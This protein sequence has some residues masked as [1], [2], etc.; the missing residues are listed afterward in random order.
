MPCPRIRPSLSASPAQPVGTSSCIF[1]SQSPGTHGIRGGPLPFPA[2]SIPHTVP[3]EKEP[4]WGW[5]RPVRPGWEEAPPPASAPPALCAS[6]IGTF[7]VGPGASVGSIKVNLL[8]PGRVR[9]ALRLAA[10]GRPSPWPSLP[11]PPMPPP[12]PSTP[13]ICV[14]GCIYLPTPRM[15]AG[16][17]GWGRRARVPG[18]CPAAQR[19][20]P[21]WQLGYGQVAPGAGP[22]EGGGPR[23]RPPR[24]PLPSAA[25]KACE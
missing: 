15:G 3:R 10:W 12:L 16:A 2:L 25:A 23:W 18:G 5:S 20:E 4:A 7:L 17:P 14:C 8:P 6:P 1:T 22:E 9:V 24:P 21:R 11:R 13:R 19:P